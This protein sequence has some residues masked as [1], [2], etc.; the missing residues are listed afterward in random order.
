MSRIRATS[1][2]DVRF[3]QSDSPAIRAQKLELLRD[4]LT[5]LA[6][7]LSITDLPLAPAAKP[8]FIYRLR[9]EVWR[10]AALSSSAEAQVA[11]T[12]PVALRIF[13]SGVQV[14]TITL[15]GTVGAVA[16]TDASFP[17]G[18][19]FEIFPPATADPTLDQVSVSLGYEIV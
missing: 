17:D 18:S 11:A 1:L 8:L 4:N 10:F 19:L 5:V 15:T 6:I 3:H 14:G 9:G 2:K 7:N 12:A 13:K 16:F